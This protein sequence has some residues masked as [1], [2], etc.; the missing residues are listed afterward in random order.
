MRFLHILVVGITVVLLL[1]SCGS[2]TNKAIERDL[3]HT[4]EA[5]HNHTSEAHHNHEHTSTTIQGITL[6]AE[7]LTSGKAIDTVYMGRVG[8]GEVVTRKLAIRNADTTAL[9]ILGTRTTCGCVAAEF[10]SE[11]IRAKR[12]ATF[13][14]RF[15]SAGYGGRFSQSIY[16]TTSLSD[17]PLRLVV[18]ADVR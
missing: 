17:E 1:G 4:T 11:P 13:D 9:A 15:D 16:I 12:S 5:H 6:S 3:A 10:S 8:A 2:R 18:T 14:V 7:R